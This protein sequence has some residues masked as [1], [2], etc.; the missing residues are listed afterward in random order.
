MVLQDF[1][2][3]G[4]KAFPAPLLLLPHFALTVSPVRLVENAAVAD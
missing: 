2:R 1:V 4:D 3:H